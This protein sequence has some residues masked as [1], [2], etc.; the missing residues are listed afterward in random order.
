LAQATRTT[1]PLP[2]QDLEP[3]RFE[4]L[5]RQLAYDFKP[6]RKLEATGR[7]G[8]DGSFDAR[9]YEIVTVDEQETQEADEDENANPAQ[10]DRL[11]LIQCKRERSI[12]PKKLRAYLDEIPADT[13]TSLYGLI[14]AAA[15][16][17]SKTARDTLTDWARANG[18]SETHVWGKGELEDQLYQ[19]KNDNILFAYFGI[20]LQIRKRS[21][22]TA[23]RSRLAMKKRAEAVFGKEY[24]ST[25]L[26]RDPTDDRY[27]STD[28]AAENHRGRWRVVSFGRLD[29]L[30]LT[31]VNR[32]HFAYLDD[33]QNGWD[34]VDAIDIAAPNG[35]EDFW[36]RKQ[37]AAAEALQSRAWHFWSDIAEKNRANFYEEELIRYE[38]IFAIDD[39]G[40]EYANCPHV[41]VDMDVDR[42][43][44][45]RLVSLDRS[46]RE[47]RNP[48]PANR[49]EFF[50]DT[51]PE[52]S[53]AAPEPRRPGEDERLARS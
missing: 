9:G 36:A 27:P 23:L 28:N 51:F 18:I 29:A 21:V 50:P 11:W 44:M 17:F 53:P 5:V 37:D 13:R 3:R 41:Y 14:F 7:A 6:W 30:G 43:S 26:L 32:R 35:H 20:S 52:P 12:P 31:Y 10:P 33:A 46:I 2:F 4:D 39:A 16:D 38:D 48:D 42:L 22:R 1:N 45:R 47:R 40:D 25:F 19:P 34:I 8:S 24:R 15:C 49:I